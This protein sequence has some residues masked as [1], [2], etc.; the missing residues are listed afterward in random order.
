MEDKN[1]SAKNEMPFLEHLEEL[2]QRI[3]K[4]LASVILFTLG[5]FPFT[6]FLLNFLTLPNDN[7]PSPA[8]LI[9][10][11]PAGMLI[12]RMEIAIAAGLIFSL[13]VI[14]YQFWMFVSPGLLYKEKKFLFPSLLFTTF[15]FVSGSFFAYKILIPVVLPFLFSMGT[16][17]IEANINITEYISFVLRLIIISGLIFELPVL[18]FFL[19]RIGVLSPKF[20]RKYRGYAVVLVFVFAAIITP[21]DPM[22]QLLIAI[23]LLFLYELSIFIALFAQKKRQK[24][25]AARDI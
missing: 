23:P 24:G 14:L 20:M 2:R 25:E 8:K 1:K 4:S 16:E 15:C 13:P 5:A 17:F 12:V 6:G 22:S 3:L 18:S 21:P 11:K 19:A 9:F 7:L 10:L